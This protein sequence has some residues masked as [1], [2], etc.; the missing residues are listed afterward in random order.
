ML[1]IK[2]DLLN[3]N[4]RPIISI[5]DDYIPSGIVS[6]IIYGEFRRNK[7]IK[8][9]AFLDTL[10]FIRNCREL[11]Y[12]MSEK[13]LNNIINRALKILYNIKDEI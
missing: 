5:K 8:Y 12:N 10:N 9:Q 13:E 11:H 2:S 6:D 3:P 7:A 4:E 1:T